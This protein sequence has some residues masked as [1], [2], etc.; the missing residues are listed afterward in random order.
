M[1]APVA[2]LDYIYNITYMIHQGIHNIICT[3]DASMCIIMV[4]IIY[5]VAAVDCLF[6]LLL[7]DFSQKCM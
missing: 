4:C 2:A 3:Y 1:H 5:I 6:F 7:F